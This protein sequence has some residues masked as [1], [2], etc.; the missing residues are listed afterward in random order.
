M[1]YPCSALPYPTPPPPR[2]AESIFVTN[3]EDPNT[4]AF[5]DELQRRLQA[6]PGG[7][8]G[9]LSAPSSPSLAGGALPC[10]ALPVQSSW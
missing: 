3:L 9:S 10:V 2:L 6:P 1:L 8:F 5:V 4:I 7:S